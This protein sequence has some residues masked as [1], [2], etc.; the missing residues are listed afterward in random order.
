MENIVKNKYINL[1]IF[2]KV[3]FRKRKHI[4]SKT[5]LPYFGNIE[6]FNNAVR[7]DL[8]KVT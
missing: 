3:K 6:V 2:W 8:N 5:A 1:K 4:K 7:V